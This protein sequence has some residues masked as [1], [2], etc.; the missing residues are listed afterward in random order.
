MSTSL[1]REIERRR[2][3]ATDL[4][5]DQLIYRLYFDYLRYYPSWSK[6]PEY[7]YQCITQVSEPEKGRLDLTLY[8]VPYSIRTR[9]ETSYVDD[10]KALTLE[11]RKDQELVFS[12]S[13]ASVYGSYDESYLPKRTTA[14]IEG[15]WIDH[16]RALEI[17]AKAVHERNARNARHS[18]A[19]RVSA[20]AARF[21]IAPTETSFVAGDAADAAA[22]AAKALVVGPFVVAGW[23]LRILIPLI[24]L[25]ALGGLLLFGLRQIL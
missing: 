19:Q 23:L 20:E 18:A 25:L 7:T 3:R 13:L 5:V 10:E 14:F 4:G 11:L 15:P 16:F 24:V 12:Q 21:G 6:R 8:G 1:E 9:R 17:E 2:R 22:A